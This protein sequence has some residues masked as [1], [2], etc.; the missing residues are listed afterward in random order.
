M[1]S[2]VGKVQPHTRIEMY[3]LEY[4]LFTTVSAVLR[5]VMMVLLFRMMKVA[6][7]P[8]EFQAATVC[9]RLCKRE[10]DENYHQGQEKNPPM[11]A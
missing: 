4:D 11:R 10:H 3:I 1:V 7:V 5:Q 6:R 9:L 2:K 8:D